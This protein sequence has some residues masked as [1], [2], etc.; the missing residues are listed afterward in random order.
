M[1]IHALDQINKRGNRLR[2]GK[3]IGGERLLLLAGRVL[4][5]LTIEGEAHIPAT[6][7]CLFAF[8]HVSQPADLIVNALIRLHRPNVYIFGLQGLQGENP[9]SLF[10][11]GLGEH[12]TEQRLLRVY[13]A[14][15]LSAGELLRALRLLKEGLSISIAAEGEYTWDGRLQYPLMPGTAWLALRS[16]T[17]V[18]PI[19]SSGG[20]DMQPRWWL[21]RMRLTG[22]LT[23]RVGHPLTLSVTPLQHL[24]DQTLSAANERL[25]Q[26]MTELFQS[27]R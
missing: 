5:H 6:G 13:K 19:V 25:W 1:D 22:R 2:L 26:A 4:N 10:L 16:G 7:P 24:D 17:P 12:D 14:R 11:Q 21:N 20:Y 8:N 3:L 9:L 23:I 18:V 27:P 15:G